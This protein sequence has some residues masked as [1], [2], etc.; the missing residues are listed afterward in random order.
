M[1]VNVGLWTGYL[2][3]ITRHLNGEAFPAYSDIEVRAFGGKC[4]ALS[5]EITRIEA[6]FNELKA[7][8]VIE[9]KK[10]EKKI[11]PLELKVEEAE[12]DTRTAKKETAT[13]RQL[14]DEEISQ[15]RKR[16]SEE[17]A[18]HKV[19]V[20]KLNKLLE[21]QKA[22]YAEREIV[23][24]QQLAKSQKETQEVQ[25]E[26][27]Y[28]E[29]KIRA[30]DREYKEM[31]ATKD[32]RIT[33]LEAE[34]QALQMTIVEKDMEIARLKALLAEALE[35]LK[36]SDY[37]AEREAHLRSI[38]EWSRRYQALEGQ[39]GM[40]I[41]TE[42]KLSK[43]LIGADKHT[44]DLQR[45]L[46]VGSQCYRSL[47]KHLVEKPAVERTASG[48]GGVRPWVK[49]PPAGAYQGQSRRAHYQGG[50]TSYAHQ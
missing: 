46:T 11:P 1:E 21:E 15:W 17:E 26:L 36:K 47:E 9:I 14:K 32:A 13:V 12:E 19:D 35:A 37:W 18:E 28:A 34:N 2:D 3:D 24:Q 4:K 27:L 31:V 41:K 50:G 6:R 7:E 39:L 25:L 42:E 8:H 38:E 48:V 16:L 23:F 30:Q 5:Q 22:R 45:E 43:A 40:S 10:I 29:D 44:K 33:E 20:D 49:W